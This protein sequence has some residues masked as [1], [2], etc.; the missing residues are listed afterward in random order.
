MA[1]QV[2]NEGHSAVVTLQ[3]S[4][5][6]TQEAPPPVPWTWKAMFPYGAGTNGSGKRASMGHQREMQG[7]HSP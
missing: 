2:K 4:A 3:E 1:K 5:V 6:L 7:V